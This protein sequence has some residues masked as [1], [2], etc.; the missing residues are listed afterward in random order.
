MRGNFCTQSQRLALTASAVLTERTLNMTLHNTDPALFWAAHGKDDVVA[1]EDDCLALIDAVFPNRSSHAPLGRG[2]DCV[3]LLMPGRVV[4]STDAFMENAHF[5]RAYFSPEEV[6]AKALASAVSDLAAAGAVPLGFS[7]GLLLPADLPKSALAG[8]LAGMARVAG[9]CAIPLTGGDISR[10]ATLGFCLTVWGKSALE[11]TPLFLRRGQ[12]EPGDVIFCIGAAGLAKVGLLALESM[13]RKAVE[14]YP[15]ACAAHLSPMPLLA[16]GAALARA[17]VGP[18]HRLGL[19]DLSDGPA[20]DL[21]RLLGT[22]GANID[23]DVGLMHPE[24]QTFAQTHNLSAEDLL[25]AGGED[26]ALLGSC[27]PESFARLRE[28]LPT[29][30]YLGEVRQEP[31]LLLRGNPLRVCGFDHLKPSKGTLD[32]AGQTCAETHPTL[33]GTAG[34]APDAAPGAMPDLIPD[35]ALKQAANALMRLCREAWSAGLLPGYSGNASMR[36]CLVDG[37]EACLITR[38]GVSKGRLSENDFA[39]LSLDDGRLI[40]GARPSS[41]AG[42]HLAVYRANP[43][44]RFVLHTHPPCLTAVSLTRP[45]QMRLRLPLFE[46]AGYRAKLAWVPDLPPGTEDLAEAAAALAHH[47]A[48]WLERHGLCVHMPE[49]DDCLALTEELEHLARITLD[50]DR[51]PA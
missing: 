16:E 49:P 32:T 35:A 36:L 43:Q 41:E 26:Y 11:D 48:L 31:G 51:R 30:A 13:G 10:S 22:Y 2:D 39:L 17:F 47:P 7:L 15:A 38:S 42:L 4:L 33:A 19:M 37:R 5:R 46:T 8:V 9:R 50:V 3:E 34:S 40:Q 20:R 18:E 6:G 1:S 25:L 14:L 23:P 27:A 45:P 28:V 44:S 12:A 29:A 24:I 21:P